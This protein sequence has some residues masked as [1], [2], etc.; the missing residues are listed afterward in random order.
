[1]A[2]NIALYKFKNWIINE[3]ERKTLELTSTEDVV[4]ET[5]MHRISWIERKR[6]QEVLGIIGDKYSRLFS[7]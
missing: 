7:I 3:T 5:C 2:H 6:N 4:L 1:M